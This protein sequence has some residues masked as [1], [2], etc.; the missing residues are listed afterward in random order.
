LWFTAD[1]NPARLRPRRGFSCFGGFQLGRERGGLTVAE[2][3]AKLPVPEEFQRYGAVYIR[4]GPDDPGH[5]L[6]RARTMSSMM[7]S[8][9]GITGPH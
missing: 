9:A 2:I 4:R 7:R 6:A 3:V 1:R 5:I 8:S